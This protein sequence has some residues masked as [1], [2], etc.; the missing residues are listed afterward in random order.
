MVTLVTLLASG[1][2]LNTAVLQKGAVDRYG[3]LLNYSC[4]AHPC[5]PIDPCKP[6]IVITHGWNPLPNRIRCTFGPAA[7]RAIK[8]RCGDSYNILSWDW[9]GVRVPAFNDGPLKIGKQQ[10]RMMAAALRNRGVMPG[11]TQ[12]VA[13][14]LGTLVTAQA[15]VCLSDLGPFA[16]L[17][18][19]D[20]PSQYHQEI[21]Y[22]LC[23]GA[24]ACVVENYW[25]PGCS[26]FGAHTDAPNVRNY[27]V[28]GET[29]IL[30]TFDLSMSNHVYVMR[31]YYDTIRCPSVRGGFQYSCL[32]KYCGR[33]NPFCE[34]YLDDGSTGGTIEGDEAHGLP[35]EEV[36]PQSETPS[37]SA[38]RASSAPL[39]V[40]LALP[41][42]SMK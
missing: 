20:P 3:I 12:I 42:R 18:L 15:A 4:G 19:L 37:A 17:T 27:I 5:D 26:G 10:G 31:W 40:E 11:R 22:E 25:S 24:H 32:L 14:S 13:H 28:K 1:C 21:F 6:T 39:Y 8:C 16:Q 2:G 38:N 9:N 7:A 30:G 33:R 36:V 41:T 29:P 23:P 34:P 35:S